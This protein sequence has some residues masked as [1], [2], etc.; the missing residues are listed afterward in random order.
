[1]EKNVKTP[2]QIIINHDIMRYKKNKLAQMLA[3]LGLVF[4]CLYFML[5]YG[6]IEN[7]YY[8]PEEPT[9]YAGLTLM[10]LSV[11][12]TL[13]IL[14][15]IFLSSENVKNYNR[16]YSYVLLGIA[17]FQVIRIFG[18]PLWGLEHQI[19]T[20]GYFGFYPTAEQS[21]VEFA[22]LTVYLCAS[23]ACLVGSAV[24]GWIQATR[25]KAYMAKTESG[26]VDVMAVVKKL[27][28][29]DEA[30]AIHVVSDPVIDEALKEVEEEEDATPVAE[31]EE[32]P[33]EPEV[34]AITNE[35]VE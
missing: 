5:L 22:I 19:L 29:A 24:I 15:V 34:P 32:E 35:E 16:T 8:N 27:D 12:I 1:M 23:A 11:I 21:G 6:I 25:L 14:L 3:L 10:G 31:S 20:V 28:A 18:Y 13:V 9:E 4:N 7:F 33:A 2:E 26:E 17:V 30:N